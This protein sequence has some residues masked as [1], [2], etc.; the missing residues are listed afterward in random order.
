MKESNAYIHFLIGDLESFIFSSRSE[1]NSY[2][3]RNELIPY[4]KSLDLL[5]K[6]AEGLYKTY[7]LIDMLDEIDDIDTLRNIFIVSSESLA[8]VLFTLPSINEKLSLF[9]EDYSLF[10]KIGENLLQIEMFIE[11]PSYP[12]FFFSDIKDNIHNISMTLGHMSS[13]MKKS[14][15]EN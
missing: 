15:I 3:Q 7:Q 11:N 14:S 4:D 2:I 13:M 8:W 10:D 12:K 6:F 5:N 1:I 9:L